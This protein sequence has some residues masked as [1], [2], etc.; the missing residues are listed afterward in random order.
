MLIGIAKAGSHTLNEVI[1]L[2]KG[3]N[4]TNIGERTLQ[5]RMSFV[6]KLRSD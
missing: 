3:Q 5:N 4:S 1:N 6:K 2:S